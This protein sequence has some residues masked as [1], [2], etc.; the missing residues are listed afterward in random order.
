M[1]KGKVLVGIQFLALAVLLFWHSNTVSPNR[2]F[3]S[4]IVEIFG[5]VI[6]V[7]AVVHLNDSIKITPEPKVNAKLVTK[8][9]YKYL[10]HPIYTGLILFGLGQVLGKAN[11]PVYIAF[12]ILFIDLNIKYRYEDKLL[13]QALPEAISYQKKTGA[14]FPKF[15]K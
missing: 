11:I 15:R 3:F 2:A 4:A 10:R 6:L 5:G 14:L 8:G 1:N 9:I 13:A 7:V 12:I